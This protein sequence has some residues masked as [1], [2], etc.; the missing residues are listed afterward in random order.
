MRSLARARFPTGSTARGQTLVV[1]IVLVAVLTIVAAGLVER[2]DTSMA[3]VNAARR[4]QESVSCADGARAYLLSKFRAFNVNPASLTLDQTVGDQ[5]MASGHYDDFGV[6]SVI[7]LA[8]VKAIQSA[9]VM[10]MANRSTASPLGGVPYVFTVVCSD[11]TGSGPNRE[12]EVEFLVRFG[13]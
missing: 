8:D 4:Y 1:V 3:T 13:L 9:S 6:A 7:P 11:S 10:G 12:T 2:S 5:R